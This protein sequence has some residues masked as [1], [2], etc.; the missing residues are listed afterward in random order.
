MSN[1]IE[2][3]S[4]LLQQI[5]D[6]KEQKSKLEGRLEEIINDLTKK[7]GFKTVEEARTWLKKEED[8]LLSLERD[9]ETK[10][11]SLKEKYEW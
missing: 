11:Q 10:Y 6:E 7:H 5:N 3:I 8:K 2:K 1:V 4:N 9:I